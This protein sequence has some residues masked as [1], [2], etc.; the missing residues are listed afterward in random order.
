M[1]ELGV[2]VGKREGK[3]AGGGERTSLTHAVTRLDLDVQACSADSPKS[4]GCVRT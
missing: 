4:L 3:G 1:E 2:C